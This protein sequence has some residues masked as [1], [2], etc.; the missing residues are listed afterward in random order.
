MKDECMSALRC[1]TC[2]MQHRKL[3]LLFKTSISLKLEFLT[4]VPQVKCFIIGLIIHL[5]T[6]PKCQKRNELKKQVF[7][8]KKTQPI[9][10]MA[11]RL[12]RLRNRLTGC[13]RSVE[14]CQNFLSLPVV[15]SSRLRSSRGNGNLSSI[16]CSNG[17][18]T[19]QPLARPVKVTFCCF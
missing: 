8:A 19:G 11:N 9:E 4:N 14:R 10:V 15:F 16:K 2:F 12:N 7:R 3:G 18:R 1:F 5:K 17:Q 6:L 13:A